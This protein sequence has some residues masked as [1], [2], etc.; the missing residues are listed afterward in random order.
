MYITTKN[1]IT[2]KAV[3]HEKLNLPGKPCNPEPGYDFGQCVRA[4][5]AMKMGCQ[6]PFSLFPVEG[7]PICQN[8]SQL[9]KYS[10]EYDKVSAMDREEILK[11]TNCVIPC[12][13]MEYRVGVPQV[14]T[15]YT[16]YLMNTFR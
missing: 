7:I 11:T 8:W 1:F 13:F 14:H 4:S 3:R 15:L 2:F 10:N 5:I 6:P 9:T 12:N 16:Q